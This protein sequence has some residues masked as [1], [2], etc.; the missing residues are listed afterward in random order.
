MR[1]GVCELVRTFNRLSS[2]IQVIEQWVSRWAC[3]ARW[4]E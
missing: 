3:W 4:V 2:S 1:K